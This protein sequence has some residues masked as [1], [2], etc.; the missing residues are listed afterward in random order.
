MAVGPRIYRKENG[1]LPWSARLLLAPCLAGQRVSLWHYRRQCRPWDEAAPGV[2]I[3]RQLGDEEAADA[4]RAGVTAVLDLTAEFSE[5]APFRGVAYRNVAI[6]DLTAP[7]P[8][9]LREAVDFIEAN[10]ASGQVYV[11]C[12]I[13]YSR[14]AAVVGAWLVESG[15]ARS[16]DE[17]MSMLRA[18]RPSIVIRPEAEA[19]LRAFTAAGMRP[20]VV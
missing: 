10:A 11:H 4:A 15:R 7:T 16:A 5:A 6:M 13:G 1:R 17:A 8:A 12:K 20:A 2:L 3:G 9:Q 18:R 14:S 19:A